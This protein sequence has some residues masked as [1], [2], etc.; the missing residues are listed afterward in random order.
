MI[1]MRYISPVR[2][3]PRYWQSLRFIGTK[4]LL[5]LIYC[6]LKLKSFQLSAHMTGTPLLT[7][8]LLFVQ[9]FF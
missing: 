4:I 7:M 9:I 3:G 5:L 6:Q 2:R 1:L 8:I